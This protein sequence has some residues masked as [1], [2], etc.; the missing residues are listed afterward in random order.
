METLNCSACEG[1]GVQVMFHN[2]A[3]CGT[4]QCP[5]CKGSGLVYPPTNFLRSVAA[6]SGKAFGE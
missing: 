2:G 3:V 4:Y 5:D 1:Q 6:R